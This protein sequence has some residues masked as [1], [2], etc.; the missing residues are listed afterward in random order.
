[1]IDPLKTLNAYCK[2]HNCTR[3]EGLTR[4]RE[5][6]DN[7][8]TSKEDRECLVNVDSLIDMLHMA[9]EQTGEDPKEVLNDLATEA[10]FILEML[11]KEFAELDIDI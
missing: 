7:F 3:L 9:C 1:M 5:E 8:V 10:P 6:Q 2:Q 4:M 11:K